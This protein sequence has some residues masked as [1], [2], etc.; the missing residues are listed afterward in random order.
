MAIYPSPQ[1]YLTSL[2]GGIPLGNVPFRSVDPT[3]WTSTDPTGL[4][5][6][7]SYAGGVTSFTMNASAASATYRLSNTVQEYPRLSTLLTADNGDGTFTTCTTDDYIVAYF[8]LRQ[9]SSP[10]FDARPFIAICADPTSTAHTTIQPFGAFCYQPG[11]VGGGLWSLTST[12]QNANAAFDALNAVAVFAPQRGVQIDTFGTDA[13]GIRIPVIHQDRFVNQS[14]T[15]GQDLKLMVGVGT[16]GSATPI[17]AGD[18]VQL[19][20]EMQVFRLTP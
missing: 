17:G 2:S 3:S 16:T 15:P 19:A 14:Y 7:V 12:E 11:N 6:G 4:L 18:V 10:G 8:R 9:F 13:T 1:S 5:S 20:Y